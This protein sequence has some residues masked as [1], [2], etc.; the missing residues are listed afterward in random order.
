MQAQE[1]TRLTQEVLISE[2]ELSS[3]IEALG[4]SISEYYAGQDLL[5][6]AILKGSVIFLADLMRAITVPHQV[7]FMAVTSYGVGA[8]ISSGV[9]RILMDLAT[10]IEGRNVLLVE[11][12]IDTGQT[13]DYITRIL[14]ERSPRSL[15]ICTLL[16][17]A[18]RR[19]V[20]IPV[21]W[22]GFDI[23]DC[24]VFGFGLDVDELHRSLPYVAVL[25]PGAS[26]QVGED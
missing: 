22:I 18:S 26:A 13:L 7:D 25:K 20:D 23:P 1:A 2:D 5:L 14:R 17:K 19:E 4:R 15:R 10:N 11:D 9:V 8:R 12:I 21:D 24:F 16:N 3:R 6:V